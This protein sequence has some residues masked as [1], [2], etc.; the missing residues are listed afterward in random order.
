MCCNEN[1]S[2]ISSWGQFDF[3]FLVIRIHLL[4]INCVIYYIQA[5]KKKKKNNSSSSL[6]AC[7]YKIMRFRGCVTLL[8][9]NVHFSV[10]VVHILSMVGKFVTHLRGM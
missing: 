9:K 2:R 7:S 1:A 3:I 6:N 10:C 8:G 5:F 4:V